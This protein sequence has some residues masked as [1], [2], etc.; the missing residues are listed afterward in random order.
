MDKTVV[1]AAL[2][3]LAS[4]NLDHYNSHCPHCGKSNQV[5]KNEQRGSTGLEIFSRKDS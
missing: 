4:E 3:Q 5:S 2:D 1:H